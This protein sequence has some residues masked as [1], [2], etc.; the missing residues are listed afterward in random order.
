MEKRIELLLLPGLGFLM[1]FSGC[2]SSKQVISG[3]EDPAK[4]IQTEAVGETGRPN[5]RKKRNGSQ[6][7]KT[8]RSR[9]ATF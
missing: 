2:L 3:Y 4:R 6:D 9:A 7:P 8:E 5:G 1:M